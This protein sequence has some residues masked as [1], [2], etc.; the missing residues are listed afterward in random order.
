MRLLRLYTTDE[1][2]VFQNNFNS[3]IV[4]EPY[5]KIAL[6]NVSF[7]IQGKEIVIDSNN[8]KLEY[9]YTTS[10]G[11]R[12][13]SLTHG[14]Y[15]KTNIDTLLADIQRK[16]NINLFHQYG[17][18]NGIEW[19][20]ELNTKNKTQI[21][22][23]QGKNVNTGSYVK[24]NVN[25]TTPAGSGAN[26]ALYFSSNNAAGTNT[27]TNFIYNTNFIARGCS[28]FNMRIQK[29]IDNSGAQDTNGFIFGLTTENI[30]NVAGKAITDSIMKL[31][32]I[33]ARPTDNYEVIADGINAPISPFTPKKVDYI[34]APINDAAK[35]DNVQ[36]RIEDGKLKAI[37]LY[38]NVGTQAEQL[39]YEMDYD[40]T[41][42]LY[43]FV[44][45][46]GGNSDCQLSKPL[47]L[48][49]PY[50]TTLHADV[51]VVD[52]APY[53]VSP[54]KQST[55]ATEHFFSFEGSTLQKYLG[56]NHIRYPLTGTLKITELTLI[57]EHDF[58]RFDVNELYIV[59][60]LNLKLLSYDGYGEE[61]RNI[62]ATIP[63][64]EDNSIVNY[65]PNTLTFIDIDNAEPIILRNVNAIIRNN[66]LSMVEGKGLAS[67]TILLKSKDE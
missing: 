36:I 31:A 45:F 65:E 56:F 66:D 61:R 3:N 2:I 63:K 11:V 8:D 19:K 34:A 27:Y 5:S 10:G 53:T 62:L 64:K 32:I 12:N 40:N 13:V 6:Q 43:P 14:T 57:A 1:N 59:E 35:N 48:Q 46:R 58:S 20:A 50:N 22:Y 51:E 39:L 26:N 33:A 17:K 18:E 67:M 28:V 49:S 9:Q 21:E 29:L 30:D 42:Q 7:E 38:D 16:L 55:K 54:T 24:T 47:F 4:I 37:I 23:K 41:Q 15:D 25:I 52:E 44:I 60:M